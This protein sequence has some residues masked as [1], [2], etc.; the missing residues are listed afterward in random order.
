LFPSRAQNPA[1]ES[2]SSRTKFTPFINCANAMVQLATLSPSSPWPQPFEM[3]VRHPVRSTA[4]PPGLPL[5]CHWYMASIEG[6]VG[7]AEDPQRR[8]CKPSTGHPHCYRGLYCYKVYTPVAVLY[9]PVAV[10]ILQAPLCKIH[11]PSAVPRGVLVLC[12]HSDPLTI[13]GGR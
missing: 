10:R 7:H 4:Q 13:H 3:P 5:D 8:P 12:T 9:T 6:V 2:L 11:T 1:T